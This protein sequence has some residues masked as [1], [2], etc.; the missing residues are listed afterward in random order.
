MGQVSTL[1]GSE[2]S[3]SIVAMG[4][5]NPEKV[6]K[7]LERMIISIIKKLS[8]DPVVVCG[9][10]IEINEGIDREIREYMK[11]NLDDMAD[12]IRNFLAEEE[13]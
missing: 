11:G 10:L 2:L 1:K 4:N 13:A 3:A 9:S 7:V 12:S 5:G 8:E 6:V